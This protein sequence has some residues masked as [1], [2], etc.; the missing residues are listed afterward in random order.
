MTIMSIEPPS[1][2][3][4]SCNEIPI[5]VTEE[6][7][8]RLHETPNL[9]DFQRQKL[10]RE[11][12]KNWDLFYKRHGDRFFKNRH[13]TRREFAELF[14]N[15]EHPKTILEIGCGCGDFALPLIENISE[16]GTDLDERTKP[17]NLYIYCC[18]MS[19]RAIDILKNNPIYKKNNPDKIKAFVAD[20][21]ADVSL[22]QSELEGKQVDLVSLIF[23][24][25]AIDPNQLRSAISN[26]YQVLKPGGMI[27]FRDYAIY[28]S[29]MLRFGA[30]SKICDQFYVR[31]D[32]TRAFFFSKEQL[33]QAFENCNFKVHSIEYVQRHTVNN[34]TKDTFDRLFL[35]AKLT[36]LS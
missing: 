20:I 8:K 19:D 24:L 21:T 31:Q 28:D 15:D 13:W 1:Y 12:K 29:A 36:K 18:D 27:L 33:Q 11:A 14:T 4:V 25:S 30:K 32:G 16:S 26:I 22:I 6:H 7:L 2:G 9:S 10:E 23:V 5:K 35:Q 17:N 3:F 34:A